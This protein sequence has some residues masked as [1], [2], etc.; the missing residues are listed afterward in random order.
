[1]KS[2]YTLVTV[3]AIAIVLAVAVGSRLAV[4]SG[5]GAQHAGAPAIG[6]PFTLVD[7]NG[8]TVSDADFRGRFMLIYFGYTFC[9]DVCPTALG[10]VATALDKLSPAERA[11]ITPIFIS[12][13]PERDTPAALKDYVAAFHPDLVGLTGSPEQVTPV[14][15]AYKVYSAKVKGADPQAYTMDHS[16]ILYLV[17]PDGRFV[18]HFPHGTTAD[19]LAAGLH[20]RLN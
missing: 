5:T 11:R 18:A 3:I 7:H 20:Q 15:K 13:D 1:M 4:W 17:G 2:R 14:L 9:P 19:E 10:T 12:I 8:R 16:S 6:G